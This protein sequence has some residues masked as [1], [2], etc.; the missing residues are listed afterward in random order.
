MKVILRHDVENVGQAGQTVEVK[1]GYGRNYLLPRN[2]A[3]PATKGNLASLGEIHAQKAIREKKRHREA[4]KI[5]DRIEKLSFNV[6]VLVG[7]DEKLFGSVTNA[8]IA[9]MLAKD[10]VTI[11]KRHIQL[12]EPIKALGVYT[13]PVKIDA[14]VSAQLRLWVV[15]KT[16]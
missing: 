12:E 15:K 9:E 6:E 16:A 14:G 8:D 7:E 4:D 10:G 11:D 3:I 5:K 13:I 2:L 1:A